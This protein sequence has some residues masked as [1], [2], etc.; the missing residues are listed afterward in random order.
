MNIFVEGKIKFN[1][2]ILSGEIS[3]GS[4]KLISMTR[5]IL[6]LFMLLIPAI[7]FAEN[8]EQDPAY[9]PPI[10]QLVKDSTTGKWQ[11]PGGWY[12]I[13]YSFAKSAAGFQLA[14]FDGQTLGTIS[15]VYLPSTNVPNIVIF[16]TQLVN[17]PKGKNWFKQNQKFICTG[18]GVTACP[19][20]P[21]AS[22]ESEKDINKLILE[23][24]KR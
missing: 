22:D 21:Y 16:N 9:C 2:I 4:A 24:P 19:F 6:K 3:Y 1:K 11:A 14:S 20:I 5:L 7:V 23:I 15:C 18:E 17:L 10:N 8:K 13:E 12:S